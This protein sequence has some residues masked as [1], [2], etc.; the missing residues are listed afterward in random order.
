MAL[1]RKSF[2]FNDEDIGVPPAISCVERCKEKTMETWMGG[3]MVI[4]AAMFS[5]LVA[6]GI[7]WMA[8]R[9]LFRVL[10]ATGLRTVPIQSENGGGLHFYTERPDQI[11]ARSPAQNSRGG[12][13]SCSQ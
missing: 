12:I 9:G 3:A 5:F 13:R 1:A 6:L 11:G 4:E 8:L 10:P 7:A 2:I